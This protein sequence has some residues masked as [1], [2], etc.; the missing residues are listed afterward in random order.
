M[1]HRC[2]RLAGADIGRAE[3][4]GKV[5]LVAHHTNFLDCIRGT[6]KK[7]NADIQA[8]HRSA[9]LVHLANIAARTG[10]MLTFDPD[11]E[12]LTNSDSADKLISRTYREHWAAPSGV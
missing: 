12:R 10:A 5:D 8:G 6:Q 3:R 7:L 9:A 1:E 4:T 2:I 11:T